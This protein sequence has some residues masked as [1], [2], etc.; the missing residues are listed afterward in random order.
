[1]KDAFI[2]MA[3]AMPW[4]FP[5][6]AFVFGA[7]VGSFLN[8][9]IYRIPAG[10]SVVRPGSH[11]AC[12]KPIAWYDNIPVLSWFILR[13]KARCCGRPFSFRY[14]A[15][16]ILTGALFLACWLRAPDVP[17][18]LCWMLFTSLLVCA[19]FVDLDTMTIPDR[20]SVGGFVFGVILSAFVPGL[21]SAGNI[22]MTGFESLISALQGAFIGTAL[23]YWIMI[24]AEIVLHRPAM[25]EGDVKLMGAIGAFCG[26]QGAVFA[27]FGGAVLGTVAMVSWAL[28]KLILGKGKGDLP[29]DVQSPLGADPEA[30]TQEDENYVRGYGEGEDDLPEGA[31]PFGPALAGG[32]LLYTLLAS[33][34]VRDYFGQISWLFMNH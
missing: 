18:A 31:L 12:G 20:C 16:E 27:L 17:T 29:E 24:M 25:G 26:W 3:R 28:T 7:C 33:D 5:A 32:A 34:Y 21:H 15:V 4:Y 22:P 8:V 11:C 2:Q 6:V 14:P 9:C 19:T 13:G 1:M 30:L 23:I 10:K